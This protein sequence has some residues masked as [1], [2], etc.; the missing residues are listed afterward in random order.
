MF[1]VLF[2]E[3]PCIDDSPEFADH[4][5]VLSTVLLVVSQTL[6]DTGMPDVSALSEKLNRADKLRQDGAFSEAEEA[7]R[8]L[9]EEA[10]LLGEQSLSYGVALNGLGATLHSAG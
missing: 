6:L 1:L 4:L 8:P 2:G 5:L 3:S 7:Y 10:R 9:M